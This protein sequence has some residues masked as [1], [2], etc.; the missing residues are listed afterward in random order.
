[1]EMGAGTFHTATFLQIH[2]SR[3]LVGGVR[4]A[5]AASH[6]RALWRQSVSPAALLPVP[7]GHQTFAA[8]D[9]R[10]VSRIAARARL[11]HAGARRPLRRGQLGIAH[12]RRLGTR[13]GSVA[14]RHG[15]HAV[16]LLPAG[17]WPRLQ[18]RHRRNHLRTRAPRDV[19]AGC[20]EHFRHRVDRRTAG[21]RHLSRRVSPERSRAVGLQLRARRYRRAAAS[22][23]RSR[24]RLRQVA[25]G[26]ARVAG[27]RAGDEGFAHV[28]SA[29]CAQGDFR[30]RTPALHPARA[31]AG[32]RS[33]AGL[34]RQPRS[35]RL[36]DAQRQCKPVSP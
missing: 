9:P 35:A 5:L 1:M 24:S 25:R 33:G 36:S 14:E 32:A 8:A 21:P 17:G 3:A 16:H 19:P 28:Q 20:R 31:H 6:R 2:R 27:V 11:R 29:G 4:A 23:R 26:E 15:S 22:L 13:V 12:A 18:T 7:G 10:S 30:D 34:L